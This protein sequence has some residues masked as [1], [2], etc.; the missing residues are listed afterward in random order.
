MLH[1]EGAA[2]EFPRVGE[3]L[4]AFR[5]VRVI[6]HQLEGIEV[7]LPHFDVDL[8]RAAGK[9]PDH[10]SYPT[11]SAPDR[12]RFSHGVLTSAQFCPVLVSESRGD[13]R[14]DRPVFEMEPGFAVPGPTYQP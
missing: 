9:K 6:D 14:T 1:A 3:P 7:H 13:R 5:A 8:L 12:S 10:G 2:N 11:L 4:D